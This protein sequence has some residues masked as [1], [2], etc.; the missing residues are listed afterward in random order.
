[1]LEIT[2]Q[3]RQHAAWV[4]EQMPPIVLPPEAA[5]TAEPFVAVGRR[6]RTPRAGRDEQGSR[7]VWT[8][9]AAAAVLALLLGGLALLR[10]HPRQPAVTDPA[11]DESGMVAT[12][13]DSVLLPRSTPEGLVPTALRTGAPRARPSYGLEPTAPPITQLFGA[14]QQPVLE[15]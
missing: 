15:I 12:A 8:A 7:W 9:M 1:M 2:D 14:D 11:T 6:G 13:P 4:D 5:R 3:L 10:S